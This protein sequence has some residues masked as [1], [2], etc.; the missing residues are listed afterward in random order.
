MK[1]TAT[2]MSDRPHPRLGGAADLLS[3]NVPQVLGDLAIDGD[4]H[5]IASS[6]RALADAIDPPQDIRAVLVSGSESAPPG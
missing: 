2:V 4:A 3:G 1:L 6:L 5:L